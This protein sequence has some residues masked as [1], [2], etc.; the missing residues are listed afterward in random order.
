MDHSPRHG[1]SRF[2]FRSV[3]D[4]DAPPALVYRALE[5]VEDYPRWWP[6]VRRLESAAGDAAT[7]VIRSALPYELRVTVTELLRDPAGG[8]LE[9]A[10]SGDVEG[11]ARW[12]VRTR[13]TGTRAV[14]EQ[15]VE[16]RRPLMRRLA[17]PGRPLFRLNHTLMMRAGQRALAAWLAARPAAV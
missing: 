7:A 1:W 6:Q 3:W 13:G 12:T 9:V 14:Y 4:L 5:R 15:E 16:V 17:V 2:R 11:W 8:V 10:L